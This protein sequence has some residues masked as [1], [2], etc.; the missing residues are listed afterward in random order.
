MFDI[1]DAKDS[2]D[3]IREQFEREKMTPGPIVGRMLDL[4]DED[5][6]APEV[7]AELNALSVKLATADEVVPWEIGEEGEWSLYFA[8][9]RTADEALAKAASGVNPAC[10][11]VEGDLEIEVMV[12]QVLTNSGRYTDTVEFEA[13]EPEEPKRAGGRSR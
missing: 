6:E 13:S 2:V 5:L 4:L 11:D 8:L 10:Y 7:L 1:K 3:S 12:R 9:A